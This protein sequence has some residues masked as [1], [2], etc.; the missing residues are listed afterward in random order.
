MDTRLTT[1][2]RD[3]ESWLRV[4][5][6][7]TAGSIGAVL[8]CCDQAAASR[9]RWTDP[10]R[11]DLADCTPDSA[12]APPEN[13]VPEAT[14]AG[15]RFQ[16]GLFDGL[17][18]PMGPEGDPP[19]GWSWGETAESESVC[20][21][22]FP[23]PETPQEVASPEQRP[24]DGPVPPPKNHPPGQCQSFPARPSVYLPESPV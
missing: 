24:Q 14:E 17:G 18:R 19:E 13:G 11:P 12:P 1:E 4:P 3:E 6:R 16:G 23:P 22:I 2:A 5:V 10:S 9:P 21:L 15:V 8:S 7:E 20:H